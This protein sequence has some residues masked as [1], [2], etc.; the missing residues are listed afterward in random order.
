MAKNRY[1]VTFSFG[2]TILSMLTILAYF[3]W[4]NQFGD[5]RLLPLL[6]NAIISFCIGL[7]VAI[8]LFYLRYGSDF[9]LT[10]F[11]LVAFIF[12][13]YAFAGDV[14]LAVLPMGYLFYSICITLGVAFLIGIIVYLFFNK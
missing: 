4:N 9:N 11:S 2:A 13:L 6:Y 12:S 1:Y 3:Y 8:V 7:G 10:G 14:K 5:I